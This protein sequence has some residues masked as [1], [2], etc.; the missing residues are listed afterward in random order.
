MQTNEKNIL[1]FWLEAETF[2]MVSEVKYN[3]K[4]PRRSSMNMRTR[5]QSK[6]Q[7]DISANASFDSQHSLS[8]SLNEEPVGN[9]SCNER[10]YVNG[11]LSYNERSYVNGPLNT[12]P[13]K[14]IDNCDKTN[15]VCDKT[16]AVDAMHPSNHDWNSAGSNYELKSNIEDSVFPEEPMKR[17]RTISSIDQ[18][19]ERSRTRSKFF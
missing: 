11:P 8:S 4:T 7:N 15:A 12:E 19:K 16:N 3:R 5:L 13:N 2:R 6:S 10:S 9:C 1:D 18:F 14:K 17:S